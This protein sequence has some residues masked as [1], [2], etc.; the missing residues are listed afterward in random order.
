MSS[1]KTRRNSLI[2]HILNPFLGH[3]SEAPE[4]SQT[5]YK[6]QKP[7]QPLLS[8]WA[9][10]VTIIDFCFQL[11][12]LHWLYS[13]NCRTWDTFQSLECYPENKFSSA[14]IG[15][16]CLPLD[17]LTKWSPSAVSFLQTG[18]DSQLRSRPQKTVLLHS[19]TFQG[20]C[21]AIS[22]KERTAQ[23]IC[24]VINTSLLAELYPRWSLQTLYI[25]LWTFFCRS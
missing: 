18:S 3:T 25:H 8:G 5:P 20:L 13:A 22:E 11:S 15:K 19:L 21:V 24:K 10:S 16:H 12:P 23:Y 2:F 6:A 17:H 4:A 14:E 7:A 9:Q 1:K